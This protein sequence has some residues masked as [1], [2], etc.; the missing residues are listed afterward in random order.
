VEDETVHPLAELYFAPHLPLPWAKS[1][2][3]FRPGRVGRT[4]RCIIRQAV[5][6]GQGF[7]RFGS[8]EE[9]KSTCS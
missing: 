7:L 6:A 9:G 5:F 3:R 2:V 1:R 8:T 4:V